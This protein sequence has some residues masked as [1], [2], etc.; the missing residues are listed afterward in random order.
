HEP[1]R[2]H[3]AWSAGL[4]T[5]IP[6]MF[7]LPATV[8]EESCACDGAPHCTLRI[9]WHAADADAT[10]ASL[11]QQN[12]LLLARLEGLQETVAQ[13]VSSDDLEVV[14]GRIIDSAARTIH[15]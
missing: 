11:Q 1:F 4:F 13:L 8:A 12:Q 15:A 5:S 7:G 10:I 2:E 3:C 6:G 14:L 9:K